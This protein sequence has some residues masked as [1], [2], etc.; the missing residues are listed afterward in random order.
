[1]DDAFGKIVVQIVFEVND[2]VIQHPH[3][4]LEV[5]GDLRSHVPVHRQ[6]FC[7]AES[8]VD[9]LLVTSADKVEICEG[10]PGNFDVGRSQFFRRQLDA[11]DVFAH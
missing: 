2:L 1:V 9:S 5:G 3:D 7:E 10:V 6:D 4:M 8:I 11:F